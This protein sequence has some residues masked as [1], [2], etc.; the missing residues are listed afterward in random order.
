MAKNQ[1]DALQIIEQ[2]MP[3]FQP[4][5]TITINEVPEMGIKGDVPI[6][7]TSVNMA[8]DYEGDFLTRRAIIYSL[9]FESRIRFYGP[10]SSQGIINT[11]SV[12][13]NNSDTFGFIEEVVETA[14]VSGIDN[15]DDNEIT[16]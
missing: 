7:L 13:I 1:D 14:S 5:Y 16:P 15:I 6:V 2:I 11:A 8:E 4:E 3:Y 9:D 12:D 10:V